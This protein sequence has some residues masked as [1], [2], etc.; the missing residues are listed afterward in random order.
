[1]TATAEAVETLRVRSDFLD[2]VEKIERLRAD[3]AERRE[4]HVEEMV[5][6]DRSEFINGEIVMPSP[7]KLKHIDAIDH[8]RDG[9]KDFIKP[10]NLG[11]CT[12]QDSMCRFPR[13]DYYP[14]ICFWPIEIS[15]TFDRDQAIFPPPALAVEVLSPSTAGRDRGV[16]FVDYAAGGVREYWIVDPDARTIEQ[17]LSDDR[18]PYR[19]LRKLD[20]GTLK[21]EVID[22]F[23]LD[24]TSVFA[25]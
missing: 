22:G 7:W 1:M 16:K 8:V 2:I 5:P 25:E 9:I 24:V 14:D 13:N 10:R 23:T 20:S 19:L 18:Q 4:R 6:G 3:E 17:Y 15:R 12:G 21:C 11:R